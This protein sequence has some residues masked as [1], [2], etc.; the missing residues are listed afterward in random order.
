MNNAFKSADILIPKKNVDMNKWSVIACD[1]YTS[2]PEYWNETEKTVGDAPSTLRITLPEIYLEDNNVSERIENI[3]RNMEKYLEENIFDEYKNVLVYVERIQNN[4]IIRQGIVGKI[5]LEEYSYEKGSTSQ[6]RATEATVIERIPPRVKIRKNASLELPHI[7][8]LIDD[9]KKN[10]IEPLSALS[11][12][13]QKLYD[14]ELMQNGGKIKGYLIPEDVQKNIFAELDELGEYNH[15]LKDVPELLYAMGDGNHSLATAK[16][17]YESLKRENPDKDFSN[18]PA[19]YALV[20]IVN[21]H[22]PA[23]QFEA[24]HR[25]VTDTDT[26]KLIADMNE[27]LEIT[28]KPSEQSFS[29]IIGKTEKKVY[30]G[31]TC[32]NLTVGSLQSFLDKWLKENG[33]KIDY[34]HGA[35]TLRT[36]VENKGGIGF[37]LPD[38]NKNQLFPT[39]IK[40]GAL[41]RKTF[42]MGHA[43]DKRFYIECRKIK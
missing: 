35:D 26:E 40:D 20:E 14:F 21:L 18:H 42:S 16:E 15:G 3:H 1:Q 32:S 28:E 12:N 4:G 10:I 8:I 2:E 31:K 30:I 23:L 13:M 24:I 41:P 17:Y 22:S 38:M 11:E 33:G 43:E 36:L 5:D 37:I 29:Y 34:I 6:V 25:I 7:M 27:F 19:R 9:E 39:V